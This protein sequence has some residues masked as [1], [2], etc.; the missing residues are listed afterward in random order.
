MAG[1]KGLPSWI[2]GAPGWLAV[3]LFVQKIVRS[4]LKA[5]VKVLFVEHH[6]FL[7]RRQRLFPFSIRGSGRPDNR[8][9]WRMGDHNPRNGEPRKGANSGGDPLPPFPGAP[10]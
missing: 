9:S 7:A 10:L 6:L 3:K 1:E 5:N 2:Q 8:W 4:E